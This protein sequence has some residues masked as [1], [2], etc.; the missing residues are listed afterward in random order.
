MVDVNVAING[1]ILYCDESILGLQIGRNY[2]I[3]KTYIDDLPFKD[4]ITDGRGQI[5]ISY[6]GSVLSDENG[7]YPSALIAVQTFFGR[8]KE[9]QPQK[10]AS[11]R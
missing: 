1:V 5:N 4:K 2:A 7:K 6:F 10:E 9:E 8:E 3:V 11:K